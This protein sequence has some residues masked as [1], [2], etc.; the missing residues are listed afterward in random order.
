MGMP[1]CPDFARCTASMASARTALASSRLDGM[2]FPGDGETG[3]L[4][5]G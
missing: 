5:D 1:G 2:Q 4:A 3:I